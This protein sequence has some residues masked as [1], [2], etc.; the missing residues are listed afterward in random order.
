MSICQ[1]T[2]KDHR[3]EFRDFAGGVSYWVCLD[4]GEMEQRY[5]DHH[6]C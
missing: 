6:G 5:E 1:V 2:F 4:C 3:L